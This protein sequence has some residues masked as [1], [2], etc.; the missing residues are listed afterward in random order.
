MNKRDSKFLMAAVAGLTMGLTDPAAGRAD[1]KPG[2]VKCFGINSCGSHA[3]CGVTD[4]D[5]KAFRALLGDKEYETRYG[6]TETHS[7]GSHAKCGASSKI[8][9]WVPTTAA[10]C[11]EKGGY[12]VEEVGADKKKVAKKA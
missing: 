9:N 5:I 8:L 4:A 2:E 10:A 3:K 11:K 7:C 1:E 12:V 6:K